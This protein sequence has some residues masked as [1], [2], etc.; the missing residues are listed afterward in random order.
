[1]SG[2]SARLLEQLHTLIGEWSRRVILQSIWFVDQPTGRY[3]LEMLLRQYAPDVFTRT[4]ILPV[5]NPHIAGVPVYEWSTVSATADEWQR[6]PWIV[7]YPGTW[8]H[9]SDNTY[10]RTSIEA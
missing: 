9:Y 5:L 2:D 4:T 1:M 7:L 10:I 3:R 6:W 8:L